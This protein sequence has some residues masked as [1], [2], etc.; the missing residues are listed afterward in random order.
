M[1]RGG[2]RPGAGRKKGSKVQ[3]SAALKQEMMRAVEEQGET[4]LAFLL[5]KM[6]E[7]EPVQRDGEGI[8]SFKV[9]Y[10]AWDKNTIEAA[11]AAAP[12]CHAKLSSIEV[13][14]E[15]PESVQRVEIAFVESA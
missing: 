11:K 4:P 7:P 10:L 3:R 9:R 6:R 12:F 14:K 15:D 5:R 13:K 1:P 2:F 8:L